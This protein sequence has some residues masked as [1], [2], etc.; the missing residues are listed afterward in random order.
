MKPWESNH[1][2]SVVQYEMISK[3]AWVW[4]GICNP[5]LILNR[6]LNFIIMK[7]KMRKDTIWIDI[8]TKHKTKDTQ[9]WKRFVTLMHGNAMMHSGCSYLICL[10]FHIGLHDRATTL[11]NA[12]IE[13]FHFIWSFFERTKFIMIIVALGGTSSQA[14]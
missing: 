14:H 12:E 11:Q 2:K 7:M 6:I 10:L 8:T 9:E 3:V 13:G 4:Y 1:A 5:M